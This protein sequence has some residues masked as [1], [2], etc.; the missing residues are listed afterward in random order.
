MSSKHAWHRGQYAA[1][2]GT[3]QYTKLQDV[4]N[5]LNVHLVG[6]EA[7]L[8]DVGRTRKGHEQWIRSTHI[9]FITSVHIKRLLYKPQG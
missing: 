7:C 9:P 4:H 8:E 3:K 1:R 5:T 6:M 2:L